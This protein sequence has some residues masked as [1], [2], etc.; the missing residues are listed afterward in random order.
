MAGMKELIARWQSLPLPWRPWRIAG[1]V[2]AADE[3]AD[4]LAYGEVILV[5]A[6]ERLAWAIFDCPCRTGHRLMLNLDRSRY[7][8]WRIES[9]RPL[10]LR[11]SIDAATSERRCHFVVRRGKISWAIATNWD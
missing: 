8:A 7:P 4:R 11:P 5:G 9:I 6:P 3:V 2:G 1:Q 10:S